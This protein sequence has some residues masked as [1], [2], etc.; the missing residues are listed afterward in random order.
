MVRAS[1]WKNLLQSKIKRV[2]PPLYL[3]VRNT[4]NKQDAIKLLKI[5]I[6]RIGESLEK[7]RQIG[8]KV[9]AKGHNKEASQEKDNDDDDQ[10]SLARYNLEISKAGPSNLKKPGDAVRI[11]HKSK[12]VEANYWGDD[13]ESSKGLRETNFDVISWAA[14]KDPNRE[15]VDP[16]HIDIEDIPSKL[17]FRLPTMPYGHSFRKRYG[18]STR[19]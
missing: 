4:T 13:N 12:G 8:S 19:V 17:I 7:D 18:D 11:I 3:V 16:V 5:V 9:E 14:Y 6:E 10:G 15:F 2:E 1:L